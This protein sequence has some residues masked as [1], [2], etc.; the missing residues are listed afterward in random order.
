MLNKIK[1]PLNYSFNFFHIILFQ[2]FFYSS[3]DGRRIS[4]RHFIHR[5]FLL[6]LIQCNRTNVWP[7]CVPVCEYL[8]DSFLDSSTSSWR[9]WDSS[10]PS[11]ESGPLEGRGW[12][13]RGHGWRRPGS[14]TEGSRWGAWEGWLFSG[15]E[16]ASPR[17]V[18]LP[19]GTRWPGEGRRRDSAPVSTLQRHFFPGCARTHTRECA[20]PA[21][22]SVSP[23]T[24]ALAS[25]VALI[26]SVRQIKTDSC[27][28]ICKYQLLH[29]HEYL[30]RLVT[31]SRKKART[32]LHRRLLRER[33]ARP[34]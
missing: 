9:E 29:F 18:S 28:K 31:P 7:V 19:D 17:G 26:V 21:L 22:L 6:T 33:N 10:P 2:A 25:G 1:T 30:R 5:L 3:Q 14:W 24:N 8:S 34:Q 23:P 13:Q 15:S 32:N 27:T 11:L 20:H 16:L 12:G 4:E